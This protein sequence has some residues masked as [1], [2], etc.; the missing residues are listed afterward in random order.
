MMRMFLGLPV[1]LEIGSDPLCRP[2]QYYS[3]RF[4]EPLEPGKQ[5]T[6]QFSIGKTNVVKPIPAEIEQ[7]ERQYLQWTGSQY[8]PSAYTTEKQKTKLKLPNNDTPEFTKLAPKADGTSDPAKT[9]TSFTYGPYEVAEPSVGGG[10]TVSIRYEYTHPVITVDKFTRDLEVSHWGGNLAI[11][12]KYWMTNNAA[13]LKNQFSRVKW[14]ATNYYSPPTAAIKSL[15]YDLKPGALGP[16]FTDEIGN[17]STSRFRSNTREA[18]LELKPRYPLFGGWNYSYTLGW[19]HDLNEFL[20]GKPNGEDFVLKVPFLEGPKEP[21]VYG[22][23]EVR[24]ILPEGATCVI[25][26]PPPRT[27]PN[28]YQRCEILCSR[29]H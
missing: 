20:R 15:T 29:P 4:S 12:E 18:H 26:C 8:F 2:T 7:T 3:V 1:S 13:K 25:P 28:F 27:R 11:E 14:A 23:V 21:V 19:N 24:I 5:I 10:E 17:V 22:E 6:L 9:G 16:Y